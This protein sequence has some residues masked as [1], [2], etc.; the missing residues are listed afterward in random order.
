MIPLKKIQEDIMALPQRE[1]IKLRD[2]ILERDW[3]QWDQQLEKDIAGGKLDFL[4]EEAQNESESGTL[5]EL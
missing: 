2:W 5:R 4:V 1:F 3:S